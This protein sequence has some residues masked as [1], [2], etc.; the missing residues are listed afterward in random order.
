MECMILHIYQPRTNLDFVIRKVFYHKIFWPFAHLTS[1]FYL[2]IRA[3]KAL[4]QI[5]V[6]QEQ[7]LM[8]RI[9]ISLA[10]LKV[11]SHTQ[12]AVVCALPQY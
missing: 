8:I 6:Y 3:G 4:L 2:F 5:L 1:S 9:K 12:L 11:L 10:Y 7:S